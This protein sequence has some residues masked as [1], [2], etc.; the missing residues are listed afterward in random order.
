MILKAGHAPTVEQ[1]DE[2]GGDTTVSDQPEQPS[3]PAKVAIEGQ[4]TAVNQPDPQ[5][6]A[7]QRA[8]ARF[9]N[10]LQ[11]WTLVFAGL[12]AL[13]AIGAYFANRRSANAA[14]IQVGILKRQV[15]DSRHDADE[16]RRIA[17]EALAET[18][19]SADAAKL[20]AEAATDAILLAHPPRIL[21]RTVVMPTFRPGFISDHLVGGYVR[22]GNVG[23]GTATVMF[24]HALW[25]VCEQLPMDNPLHSAKRETPEPP[26]FNVPAGAF[27]TINLS[28][29]FLTRQE[30]ESIE[31]P[32]FSNTFQKSKLDLYVIGYIKYSEPK[33]QIRR[34]FFCRQYI[35]ESG[36]F[37]VVENP[38][39]EYE[40]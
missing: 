34:V 8:Q 40:D 7:E 18:R 26:A 25:L 19:K 17:L 12:A 1:Q 15:E 16:Q 4:I 29:R 20:S 3:S 23:S 10:S 37:V 27:W 21:V 13:G 36:R 6:Q 22:A 24:T 14:E 33:R 38:D 2:T 5:Q 9:S 11:V 30:M 28:E 32:P 39:Y 31:Q 35:H